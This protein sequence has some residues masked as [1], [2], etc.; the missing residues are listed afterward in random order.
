MRQI[1]FSTGAIA[2]SDFERGLNVIAHCGLNAVE[3]SALRIS[4]IGPLLS[5]LG[6]LDLSR[7]SYIS[8]HAPSKY[9]QD[10][11]QA[12]VAALES[13]PATWPIIVHPD[14]IF[15]FSLWAGLGSRIAVENM[16]RRKPIGRTALEMA[17]IF[18]K[19][20]N[21]RMCFDIGHARQY[22]ASMF[23][24]FVILRDF[25][26]RIVQVHVSEVDTSNRHNRVSYAAQIAFHQICQWLPNTV[27]LILESRVEENQVVAEVEM[28]AKVFDR[29]DQTAQ[30]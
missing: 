24:A 8:I 5:A 6:E 28:V 30:A 19:L 20:P 11:E 23:E 21:A 9:E 2:L 10:E 4:E 14:A 25:K 12:L 16:D 29:T 22:D 18:E 17:K 13:V 27:P 15:D 26:D 1:G 3:L 7:Y